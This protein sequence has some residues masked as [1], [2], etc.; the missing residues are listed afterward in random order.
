MSV[1]ERGST[2]GGSSVRWS[3][4]IWVKVFHIL[5]FLI[6]GF[7]ALFPLFWMVVSSFKA[8]ADIVAMPMRFFPTKWITDNYAKLLSGGAFSRSLLLTTGLGALFVIGTL[9]VNSMAGYAFAR[10]EF[11][12]KKVLWPMVLITMFIPGI[13][14]LITSFI[15]VVR[16]GMLNTIWVL[17]L[18]GLASGGHI[19]FIRQFYLNFP[20]SLEEASMIDGCTRFQTYFRVFLPSS[21]PV[22]VIVGVSAFLG[23]WGSYLWPVMT[24]S[25]QSLY[26]I[27][28]LMQF[29]R[30]ERNLR[31]GVILAGAVITSIPPVVLFAIFQRYIVEGIKISGLK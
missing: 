8:H 5:V 2:I 31:D 28:Q 17:I 14:I 19:F 21:L 23:Y 15:V 9:I 11:P 24:I 20:L 10:L 26:Q 18:P 1:L 7:C 22:F 29:F 12:L 4:G 16:L 30:S 6:V 25:K 27:M 13:S 3:K